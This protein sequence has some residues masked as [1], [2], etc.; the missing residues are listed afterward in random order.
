[1]IANKKANSIPL[2]SAEFQPPKGQIN[3][4]E[5]RKNKKPGKTQR[6]PVIDSQA[7]LQPD[8]PLDHLLQAAPREVILAKAIDDIGL[9]RGGRVAAPAAAEELRLFLAHQNVITL[10]AVQPR[11]GRRHRRTL[12][13]PLVIVQR[14][15]ADNTVLAVAARVVAALQVH[16]HRARLGYAAGERREVLGVGWGIG[17]AAPE[18]GAFFAF[19][20]VHGA[21]GVVRS[22]GVTFTRTTCVIAAFFGAPLELEEGNLALVGALVEVLKVIVVLGRGIVA[23]AALY[24]RVM[25]VEA[26]I[27]LNH[28]INKNQMTIHSKGFIPLYESTHQNRY[29]ET[30]KVPNK[31]VLDTVF[32][33]INAHSDINFY[34]KLWFFKRGST[35]KPTGFIG[36]FFKRGSTWNR[37]AS[38]GDFSKGG[39]HTSPELMVS[40]FHDRVM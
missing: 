16:R 38:M 1:M 34:Q 4:G 2:F 14:I 3:N 6:H 25:Q 31:G 32:A 33:E 28:F 8:L 9:R 22:R 17:G 26:W 40:N 11:T 35:Q 24:H 37:W 20:V 12:T 27:Q 13:C 29:R 5:V 21:G 7:L 36:W 19:A 15:A 18:N 39:V 23:G 30:E 10:Q